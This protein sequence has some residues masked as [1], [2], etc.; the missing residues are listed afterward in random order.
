MSDDG[1]TFT[2]EKVAKTWTSNRLYAICKDGEV[3]LKLKDESDAKQ[4]LEYLN[5]NY[6]ESKPSK[7]GSGKTASKKTTSKKTSKKTGRKTSKK[8]S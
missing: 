2:M 4:V 7:K 6:S 3:I 5:K 1:K 8:K